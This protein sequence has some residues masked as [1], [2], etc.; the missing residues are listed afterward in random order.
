M[1][2]LSLSITLFTLNF[3]DTCI[4]FD[5][6]L[7]CSHSVRLHQEVS[8]EWEQYMRLFEF[9]QF[10]L[11]NDLLM[12]LLVYLGVVVVLFAFQLGHELV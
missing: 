8:T 4:L 3:V 10:L 6:K 12:D 2:C 1:H 5:I 7:L 9:L 11:L